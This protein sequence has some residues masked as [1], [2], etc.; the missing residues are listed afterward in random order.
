[1]AWLRSPVFYGIVLLCLGA[2]LRFALSLPENDSPL[3]P[4]ALRRALEYQRAGRPIQALEPRY[5]PYAF[6]FI[7]AA[8]AADIEAI[9]RRIDAEL[10]AAEAVNER[11]L[12]GVPGYTAAALVRP[13]IVLMALGGA[14]VLRS[15]AFVLA[16]G[17]A[18]GGFHQLMLQTGKITGAP[19]EF[20]LAAI[21][22]ALVWSL[23][24][25]A[26]RAL[27]EGRLRLRV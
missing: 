14:L 15:L 24:F 19:S 11:G 16:I 8:S 27:Y 6:A 18:V 22:A 1:M 23:L 10:A 12:A 3:T 25:W 17:F 5:R 26:V 21:L 7:L 9:K 20:Y 13:D 2:L 4:E